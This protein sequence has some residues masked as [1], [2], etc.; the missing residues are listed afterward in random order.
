MDGWM[1]GWMEGWIDWGRLGRVRWEGGE[2]VEATRV[3]GADVG[4]M[5][6]SNG[7]CDF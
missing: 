5:L 1:D 4:W 3:S 7:D 2:L 6:M